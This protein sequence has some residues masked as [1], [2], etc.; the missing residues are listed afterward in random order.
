MKKRVVSIG[1]HS[2]DA[3][4]MGGL[5][6]IDYAKKGAKCTFVHIT[7][8]ERGHKTLSQEAYGEQLLQENKV[9]AEKMGC[10]S[11]WMGY[12]AGKLPPHEEF[13]QDIK[14]YLIKESVD[15]VITHWIGTMHKRHLDTHLAVRDAV[16][17]MQRDGHDIDLFYGE[18]CEDLVGFIPQR[19]TSH[20]QE[21]VD[22]WFEALR[23]YEIFRGKVNNVP[24]YDY[25]NTSLKVRQIESFHN[26][27]TR[28][29]MYG[30]KN[31]DNLG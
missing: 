12:L 30:S 5:T 21:D 29:F 11:H 9:V 10:D 13:M 8:G 22:L 24:Y 26:G 3:E 16:A 25:Y 6:L 18:N 19:Y 1:A 27:Y 7:R 4:L 14:D 2:L 20:S 15:L 28:A 17:Q 31:T 23:G